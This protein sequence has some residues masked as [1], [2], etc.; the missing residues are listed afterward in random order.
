MILVERMQ[1]LCSPQSF[2]NLLTHL[3]GWHRVEKQ[4]E[5]IYSPHR[6]LQQQM[7]T[8][9]NGTIMMTPHSSCMQSLTGMP[10]TMA[11]PP[12][13]DGY[14]IEQCARSLHIETFTKS[15]V[16]GKT[17]RLLALLSGPQISL[18]GC[19]GAPVSDTKCV[20][21][22]PGSSNSRSAHMDLCFSNERT[23]STHSSQPT[24]RIGQNSIGLS[25][26]LYWPI[27]S[28]LPKS[29]SAGPIAPLSSHAML[30]TLH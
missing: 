20:L 10:W 27:L 16:G 22:V 18:P 28:I 23:G 12:P 25:S 11:S 19:C 5:H 6:Q 1:H 9:S 26:A 7:L 15:Q 29:T 3:S 21:R 4:L 14:S 30:Q 2:H 17:C 13:D 8:G 24:P